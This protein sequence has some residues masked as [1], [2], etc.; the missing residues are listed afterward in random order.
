MYLPVVIQG[1]VYAPDLIPHRFIKLFF[2][3]ASAAR[4][5]KIGIAKLAIHISARLCDL[6]TFTRQLNT[7]ARTPTQTK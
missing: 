3:P 7:T 4:G 2:C 6:P 5:I 1:L